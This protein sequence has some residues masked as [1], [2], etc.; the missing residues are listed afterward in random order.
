MAKMTLLGIVQE[1]LSDM[2]SDA[3]NSISDTFESQQV[4]KIVKRVYFNLFEERVWPHT[5]QLFKLTPSGDSSRPT[6]MKIEDAVSELLWVKYDCK[7]VGD[8]DSNY[9][10]IHYKSPEE[11][12][13]YVMQRDSSEADVLTVIDFR[14]APLFIKTDEAPSC[15]TTFDDEWLIFDS[16][17]SEVDSTLQSS[18]TQVFGYVEPTWE[19]TDSFIPHMP[20]K[21]F[22]LLIAEAKS[23]AFLKLKE[24]FSQKDEQA[25]TRQ[26][27]WLSREKRRASEGPRYP[28]YGRKSPGAT[29]KRRY[30][31]DHYTG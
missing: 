27:G 15:F 28:D 31:N 17:D 29:V 5:G 18:K 22:G 24:V 20:S 12:V 9:L 10:T 2:T 13:E 25:A 23:Q 26:R 16:Y 1:I 21:A 11:F 8:A 14:G 7:E 3:V 19:H 6:H 30:R 4:A